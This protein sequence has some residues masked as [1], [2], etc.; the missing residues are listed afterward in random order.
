MVWVELA[1]IVTFW[2]RQES[3]PSRQD[4]PNS[5]DLQTNTVHSFFTTLIRWRANGLSEDVSEEKYGYQ[6]G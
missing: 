3:L 6:M 5:A 1:Q 4:F 2:C